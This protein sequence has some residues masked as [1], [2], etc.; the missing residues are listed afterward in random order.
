MK[1]ILFLLL[2]VVAFSSCSTEDYYE[3]V[4][5][6]NRCPIPQY[7]YQLNPE[8]TYDEI[9]EMS[10]LVLEQC[11]WT[12]GLFLPKEMGMPLKKDYDGYNLNSV[13]QAI[14]YYESQPSFSDTVEETWVYEQWHKMIIRNHH[15]IF[16]EEA[17]G[18]PYKVIEDKI[19]EET[20]NNC[21]EK[22]S[23]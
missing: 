12:P 2:A 13:L 8:Y 21:Y 7:R 18:N 10:T 20:I 17:P 6:E 14:F 11:F 9:F 16:D 4:C 1:K 22:S 5:T 3:E 23:L 19:L 15:C